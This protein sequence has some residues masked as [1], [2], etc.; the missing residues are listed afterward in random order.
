MSTSFVT[1]ATLAV[2]AGFLVVATQAFSPST[3]AWIAFGIAIGILALAS[4][5]Q[6]DTSRGAVQRM[7]D[8]IVAIV[9]AWTIVASVV[10]DG[11]TLKWLT[12]GE[13]VALF[14]LAAA[15]LAYN[16][17]REQK[18]VRATDG[19]GLSDSLRAAA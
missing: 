4:L 16:E 13:A 6:A 5:A 9:A 2:A 1:N 11:T 19:T 8:G 10:F 3:T 14:A 12:L 7:L 18:A 17:S 15:G